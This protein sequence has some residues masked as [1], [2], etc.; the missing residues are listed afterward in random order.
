MT[1]RVM[2]GNGRCGGGTAGCGGLVVVVM[3]VALFS[4]SVSA[5]MQRVVRSVLVNV[6][7]GV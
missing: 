2:L 1:W 6:V 5:A 3:V 7:P 4:G